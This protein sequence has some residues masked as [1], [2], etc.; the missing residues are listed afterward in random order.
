[1]GATGGG[2]SK[3]ALS[4]VPGPVKGPV[5]WLT[6][7]WASYCGSLHGFNTS[8]IAG[9]MSMPTFTREFGW[10]EL[11]SGTISNYKGW[12]TSS[13]LLGQTVGILLASP[14]MESRGRKVIIL[15]AA[16]TYTIGSL[17]MA[18]NFGSLPELLVG[19]II[20]GLGSGLA[21]S[22]GPCYLSEI[23][24]A[25]LRGMLSTFYNAGIMSS[26]AGA[27]WINYGSSQVLSD[28]F[29]WVIPM[30]LQM[31]P[32]AI[33]LLGHPFVPE[34]PR[35]LLM[36]GRI[37]EAKR[38]L[39]RLRGG[40]DE[41][42]EYF[43]REWRDLSQGI[44]SQSEN[45][46]WKAS[47]TVLRR[48]WTEKPVRKI[49]IFVLIIQTFFIMSGGNS[50]TYYAPNILKSVGFDSQKVL[51]FTA[52]YGLI[53]FFSV[54]IYA[55]FLTERFG[56]R[57][58]LL[59]GATVNLLC[60]IY[61]SAYLGKASIVQNSDN[62]SPAAI[63]AVISICIFAIGY[64]VGWGP[65]FSVASSEI[66]PT[67]IRGP[68]V[69]IGFVYQNLLNFGITRG[70]PNMTE[71]MHAYGPFAL[72]A[73]FTLCGIFWVFFA[74]PE[75]RGRSM[76]NTESLFLLP[77][78]KIGFAPVPDRFAGEV[79]DEEKSEVSEHKENID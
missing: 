51:L 24:P 69:T 67:S 70:F 61:L 37:D 63:V 7:I 74:F 4:R 8:N 23:A 39:S 33:L 77:W 65:S 15:I 6:A 12:V 46:V 58:L 78:Y 5:I 14:I 1:M 9:V 44:E 79:V 71:D 47:A 62:A 48:V 30:I 38:S 56:R 52:V 49:L 31:I 75:C 29:Q 11:S 43:A 17:L 42:H 35:F 64:G 34:S 25:E 32:A 28:R 18:V 16:I 59:I 40:L 41:T 76:E 21:Y 73:A 55:L 3:Q 53:K 2:V 27:Y 13:M 72:F 22:A 66:C 68:I 50:I 60:L 45:G 57:P 36:V 19:R 10:N 26:V 54:L 20:S